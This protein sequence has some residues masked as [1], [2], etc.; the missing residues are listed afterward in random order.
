MA[1]PREEAKCQSVPSF[2]LEQLCFRVFFHLKED[3]D[4]SRND[5]TRGF[6]YIF[7]VCLVLGVAHN[8]GSYLKKKGENRASHEDLRELVEQMKSGH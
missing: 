2:F 7:L 3:T 4:I 8:F 5:R 1:K 6:N